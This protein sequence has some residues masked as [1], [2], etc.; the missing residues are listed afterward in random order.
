MGAGMTAMAREIGTPAPPV[1]VL[2]AAWVVV[3]GGMHRLGWVTFL[4]SL[5]LSLSAQFQCRRCPFPLDTDG[6]LLFLHSPCVDLYYT[7][8]WCFTSGNSHYKTTDT[9]QADKLPRKPASYPDALVNL[10]KK[11]R[12]RECRSAHRNRG[13]KNGEELSV[14]TNFEFRLLL[15]PTSFTA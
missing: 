4:F 6:V 2:T 9:N 14:S 11:F 10:S 8:N 7:M 5:S 12:N 1:L 13:Q 15:T 3:D